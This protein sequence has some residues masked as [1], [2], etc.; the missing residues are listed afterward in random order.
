MQLP[1]L[2]STLKVT[3]F[4]CLSKNK[5]LA[6]VMS[7]FPMESRGGRGAVV[8]ALQM[9]DLTRIEKKGRGLYGPRITVEIK[10]KQGFI[11][12]KGGVGV[13]YCN[14]C[15]FQM[16]KCHVGH[17]ESMYDF[18]PL[19]LYSGDLGRMRKAL[20]SLIHDPHRNLRIF[21]EGSLIHS[22]ESPL[23]EA[24]LEE[25]F[26]PDG[27]ADIDDFVDAVGLG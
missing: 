17:F 22:D 19:D 25:L 3:N 1:N 12:R 16:E 13:P 18:C 23:T 9:E 7:F 4:N 21:V 27:S 5:E 15:I 6:K 24:E 11:Q 20:R 14:N 10:P 8:N 26:F 2:P